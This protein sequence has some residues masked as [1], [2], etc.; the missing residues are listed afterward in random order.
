MAQIR[1][2]VWRVVKWALIGLGTVILLLVALIIFIS[3]PAGQ[4]FVKNQG[5]KYLR[6][7]LQTNLSIGSFRF[8]LST[9]I[10]L[11]QIYLEDQQKRVLL[12]VN[13]LDVDYNFEALLK[14][15]VLLNEIR[16]RGVQVNLFRDRDSDKFNFNFIP[17][18]FASNEPESPDSATSSSFTINLGKLN[19]DSIYFQMDDQYAGQKYVADINQFKT[20]L[21]N[22]DLDKMIFHADYIFSDGINVQA[23]LD[24][25]KRPSSGS[26][27]DTSSSNFQ[28]VS[29][30][31]RLTRT[32]F[33][34]DNRSADPLTLITDVGSMQAK[35]LDYHGDQQTLAVEII[36]L[37]DHSTQVGTRTSK[38]TTEQTQT[39][40]TGG[41]PF[42]FKID[43]LTLNNNDISY[44]DSSYPKLKSRA[45][46]YH[47]LAV[48]ALN[49]RAADISSDGNMYNAN[50]S[51]LS[52][53]ESSGFMV[54]YLRSNISY[55]D[56]AIK[57][58]NLLIKTGSNEIAGNADV[59]IIKRPGRQDNYRIRT[60]ITTP[61]LKLSEALYFQPDLAK[62]KY[63]TPLV[64]KSF[65]LNTNIDGMLD[66]L[67]IRQL[68]IKEASTSI[69]A[70]AD[71]KNLP[72]V[73]RM[74]ITLKLNEFSSTRS[75]I[76]ALLP[77]GMI[78]DSLL[79][80]IPEKI[81]LKGIY[82]GTLQNMY[83]DLQLA[84]SYG[85]A[86][87]KGTLRDITD[88]SK[89]TYDLSASLRQIDLA[90]ILEDTTLGKVNGTVTLNGKGYDPRSM[91]TDYDVHVD[92]AYYSGYTYKGLDIKGDIDHYV[93]NAEVYSEDPNAELDGTFA[94]DLNEGKR[95]LK[96]D[97]HIKNVDLNKLGFLSDSVN[98]RA[99]LT[100]DFPLADT[101]GIQGNMLLTGAS[102]RYN[103]KKLDLDTVR[104][105]AH[106]SLDSQ[107]IKLVTP[108]TDFDLLGKY[109]LQDVPGAVKTVIN[110]YFLVGAKRD[111]AFTSD[112]DARLLARFNIPDSIASL[113]G[114]LRSISPFFISSKIGSK[115][116]YIVF[117]TYIPYIKYG[118]VEIDT[119]AV[120]LMKADS[121]K[122]ERPEEMRFGASIRRLVGPSYEL[123][124]SILMGGA[125]KGIA[126]GKLEFQDE[127]EN[128]RYKLPFIFTNDPERPNVSIPDSLIINE[129][130][131]FVS[132]DN[133]IYLDTKHLSG[134][135][136][137]IG[138]N[139]T[140]IDFR[141]A[142]HNPEGLPME[143]RINQFQIR[144]LAEIIISD[145][146]LANGTIN[147]HLD[148]S[149]ITP[150]RF[151]TDIQIDSLEVLRSKLG[152]LRAL[153]EQQEDGIY[154]VNTTLKNDHNDVSLLGTYNT[155]EKNA[156]LDLK[157]EKFDL[158]D[159]HPI[160]EQYLADLDGTL[161]GELSLKGSIDEPQVRGKINA[162]SIRTIYRMTGTYIRIPNSE[163]VFDE[164]GMK[165]SELNI[166]DS[167]GNTGKITGRVNS[168]D[169]RSFYADLAFNAKNFQIVGR[170]KM[171]DQGIYGPTNADLNITVKGTQETMIIEGKVDVKDKSEFTYIYKS[172][173]YDQIGEGLVEFFDPSNPVDTT[174][175][176]KRR[177][178]GLGFQLL[179]NMYINITPASS[180]TIVL[181]ELSGD[182]LKAKGKADLNFLMKAGGGK[183]LI[184]TYTL[185]DGDYDLSIAGLVRKKFKIQ[186][187]STIIWAGDPLKGRMDITAKYETKTSAGELVNDIDHIPGIDKQKLNFDVYIMLKNE[188]LKPEISFKLDMDEADQQ[189]FNGMI[190]TRIKQVNSIPAELNKQVMGLLAFNQFIAEN[191]FSSFTSSG[192]DFTTQAFNTAGKL[193]TQELTDL[194][195]K[196][197]KEV[198]IDFGL[199]RQEDYT[200]GQAVQRTD[201][202]VGVSKSFAD[203]RL[204]VYVG[205]TFA[206]EG[207]NQDNEALAGL[208]GD[209]T[210][211]YL[212]TKDGKYRLKGYRLTDNDLIFQGNV[213]RTGVSFVVVLEFN[214]FKN[215][216]RSSKNKKS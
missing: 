166:T 35:G 121:I 102:L 174:T 23:Y 126:T 24:P 196:Y 119:L 148:I 149:S 62:N 132:K 58:Q 188:L 41:K 191:P 154:S 193:L 120:S 111:T 74:V 101:Q 30:T 176:E 8:G 171:A 82:K 206:L 143:L 182:H 37:Q 135:L 3:T 17:E 114:D 50:I 42:R 127:Y 145:T 83:A 26:V 73:D 185:D 169:Y 181:D 129:K 213:V 84:S 90:S 112:V 55:S 1:K 80:Y 144:D 5:E 157:L 71:I 33:R 94:I 10:H 201:L 131:W 54:K 146:A 68:V 87:L 123:K 209:V 110:N 7:K 198:N 9:G 109:K 215:M 31:I 194:V 122:S 45:I 78:A 60:A 216:F 91:V 138:N 34:L 27:T 197:V 28:F 99:D 133:K 40:D 190:Y 115:E 214:K 39:S 155:N 63:F 44:T 32:S 53:K 98:I 86:S 21:R 136:L 177:K 178:A 118:D 52:A 25:V 141:T 2:T 192:G 77:K 158:A 106:Q 150:F 160:T 13:Q 69:N 103:N 46:D 104:L 79:H 29:D 175:V 147:G 187:G 195:G 108:Y 134:S 202:Q 38:K 116:N 12:S 72:D 6:N 36:A 100:A 205:S 57:I 139:G 85:N 18:A 208:A 76:V 153:V 61:G 47:H 93:L 107:Y 113:F 211:E 170:R 64:N 167:M 67:H 199:E 16:L 15:N 92:S 51:E 20:D 89:A 173:V 124:K 128:P 59:R 97:A 4:N 152:N 162:D 159:L 22:T 207:S 168:K 200:S 164:D 49:I 184:G 186:N 183:E 137:T 210:L 163:F 172:D 19:L 125:Y 11:R 105:D 212:L 65:R 204:N 75:N 161:T 180:V 142:D 179:M 56:T 95:S 189:A 156:D 140:T 203:N 48:G 165:F 96:T 43:S 151:T 70:S 81:G 117:F 130:K 66:D 88:K 14:K